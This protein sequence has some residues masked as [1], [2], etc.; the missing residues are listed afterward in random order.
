MKL[1]GAILIIVGAIMALI[2]VMMQTSVS[3][4]ASS[5]ASVL[6][7]MPSEVANLGLIQRQTIALHIG[8]ALFI[9]GSVLLAGGHIA[10]SL[11]PRPASP[12][13]AAAPIDPA[14]AEIERPIAEVP[15]REPYEE[16]EWEKKLYR[17]GLWVIGV[18]AVVLLSI[19]LFS[20]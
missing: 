9:G 12:D 11:A 1:A 14:L 19:T 8:L 7:S 18:A 4:D 10:D 3:I 2:A 17:I 5:Y 6:G 13:Q 20:R 15:L 16:P